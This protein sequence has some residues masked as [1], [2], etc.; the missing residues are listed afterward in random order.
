MDLSLFLAQ[1]TRAT[2]LI[3]ALITISEFLT[4]RD[5]TRLDIALMFLAL[6]VTVVAQL[7]DL[8]GVHSQL[9]SDVQAVSL[10]AQPFLLVR[11]AGHFQPLPRFVEPLAFLGWLV[12]SVLL[13][14]LPR[15]PIWPTLLAV[16][17]FGV[18]EVYAA[19][20]F[21]RGARQA[22]GVTRWRHLLAA[23][24]SGLVA[25]VIVL[26]GVALAAPALQPVISAGSQFLSL[27]S[28]L[29]YY[30]GFAPPRWLRR[31]W[32]LDELQRFLQATAGKPASER[33]VGMLDSLCST[34]VRAVGG[35]AAVAATGP[36]EAAQ[37]NIEATTHPALYSG[38]LDLGNAIMARA[39]KER[40]PTAARRP[41]HLSPEGK[42]L[43]SQVGATSLLAV[44][45][46]TAERAWGL[47]IV[48]LQRSLLFPDDDL[49]LL[50]LLCEQAA[51]AL[52]QLALVREQQALV[53][54]L[55]ERS[56]QLEAANRELEAFSYSVSH[57]LRAPLRHIEG[58]TDLLRRDGMNSD[59]QQQHLRRI[60][61]AAVRM[62]RLIDDLLTFSRMAR[63]EMR[64][65]TVSLERIVEDARSDLQA[66][67]QGRDVIWQVAPLP[68]VDADAA[69][70]RLALYNLLS[71]A[72]K[73]TRGREP[74]RIEVGVEAD[75]PDE[76]VVFVKDNGVGF[77]MRYGDKLFGVFQ[78]LHHADEFEG[79]GIG[80]A[81][82]R[83]IIHRHG[84]RTWAVGQPGEGATFFFSLPKAAAHLPD[85]GGPASV[86]AKPQAQPEPAGSH[87][88]KG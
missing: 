76:V 63:A 53:A 42:R 44:P 71:N 2:Y 31:T 6:A 40:R 22:G 9:I 88:G 85:W 37:L 68:E 21:V 59:Q 18:A 60:S 39:W 81:N 24:G 16:A 67:A 29:A 35:R 62:G 80:L 79:I 30:L 23:T 49:G 72:V 54:D 70:L 57:D 27:A 52:E 38:T 86:A 46:Q 10:M 7:A 55:R 47:L 43:A 50:A 78:R 65:E 84:G 15:Q 36:A 25:A 11:L 69:L 14:A 1:L 12:S 51:M 45:I 8:A 5:Q 73:Y 48:L 19:T 58:F 3:I 74:A 64:I 34:A 32:R 77:D 33:A 61:E 82:V 66:E 41:D 17:Y 4:H 87:S 83:R 75:S 20:A 56:G 13:V 28:G 26:A